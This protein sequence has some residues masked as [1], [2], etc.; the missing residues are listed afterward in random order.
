MRVF[1]WM[2]IIIMFIYTIGFSITLWK[3]KSKQGAIAVFIIA[4]LIVIAPFFSVF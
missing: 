1:I 3:E 4:V 2:I